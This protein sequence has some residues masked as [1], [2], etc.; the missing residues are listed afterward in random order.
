MTSLSF[1]CSF[2]LMTWT[3]ASKDF[4]GHIFLIHPPSDESSAVIK[5]PILL[6]KEDTSYTI[7]RIRCSKLPST[8][9]PCAK[10]KL[11]IFNDVLYLSL[12]LSLQ[13]QRI[14]R[15]QNMLVFIIVIDCTELCTHSSS[16]QHSLYW[17]TVCHISDAEVI[18]GLKLEFSFS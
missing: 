4:L 5:C 7:T 2:Y 11:G 8:L 15:G 13:H 18:A 6:W 10:F 17:F 3:R 9:H 14:P 1:W 16:K 12:S